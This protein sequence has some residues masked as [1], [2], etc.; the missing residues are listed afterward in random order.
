[1]S[2][3]IQSKIVYSIDDIPNK[4]NPNKEIL[5]KLTK[6]YICSLPVCIHGLLSR[7]TRKRCKFCHCHFE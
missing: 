6:C 5:C 1:M 2:E 3:N 4:D 7:C